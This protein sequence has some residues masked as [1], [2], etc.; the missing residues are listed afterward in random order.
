[1]K[2]SLKIYYLKKGNT[3]SAEVEVVDQSGELDG[4]LGIGLVSRAGGALNN[5]GG[6]LASSVLEIQILDEGGC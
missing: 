3:K 2:P 6:L 5:V 1:M 4:G